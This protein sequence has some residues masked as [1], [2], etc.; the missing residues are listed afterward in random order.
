[1]PAFRRVLGERAGPTAVGVLVPPGKRTLVVVRPRALPWDLVLTQFGPDGLPGAGFL[2][3][4]RNPAGNAAQKL[5]QALIHWA[6]EGLG[7]A[8]TCPAAD[9]DGCWIWAEIEGHILLVCPRQPGE[10]YRP[11]HFANLED[12]AK[13]IALITAALRP[14]HD[15]NC[16]LYTNT[17]HFNR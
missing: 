16:E 2:E 4:G 8:R 3:M 11:A 14:T 15:A 6:E 17:Q 13:A 9:G 12:A 1:M 10:A 5:S 7:E